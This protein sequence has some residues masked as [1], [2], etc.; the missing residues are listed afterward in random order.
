MCDQ[1]QMLG[2]AQNSTVEFNI[3]VE[4]YILDVCSTW[5]LKNI[6]KLGGQSKIVQL[7]NY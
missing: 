1:V 3:V 2:L 4:S 7:G 6:I 5:L